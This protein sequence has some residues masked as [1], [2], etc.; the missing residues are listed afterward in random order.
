MN[1]EALNTHLRIHLFVDHSFDDKTA[2]NDRVA[3]ITHALQE[4][5]EKFTS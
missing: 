3:E 4:I 5:I 1:T 2:I